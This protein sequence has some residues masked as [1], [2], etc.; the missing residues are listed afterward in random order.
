MKAISCGILV[1]NDHGE[2]FLGH[3][4]G[5]SWWDILKGKAEEGETPRQT[6]VREA[7]EES[8]L[9]FSPAALEDL[10]EFGYQPRKDLHL[11]A[12][13]IPRS[14]VAPDLCKCTAFF[15]REEHPLG[16][17]PEM[18]RFA[19]VSVSRIGDYC[20]PRMTAVLQTLLT[21]KIEKRVKLNE[22]LFPQRL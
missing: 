21:D 6:A 16:R 11:F 5:Q 8:G 13:R 1:L 12:V 20:A 19:W 4:T 14:R 3:A 7:R 9:L 2:I 18:D 22:T 17:I 15:E 10:G